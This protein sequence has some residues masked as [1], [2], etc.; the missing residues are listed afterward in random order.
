M[1]FEDIVQKVDNAKDLDQLFELWQQAHA[2]EKEWRNTTIV[3]EEWGKRD[4]LR[5]Y[6]TGDGIIDE[7]AYLNSP[8]KVLVVLKEANV[9]DNKEDKFFENAGDHRDWYNEFVNGKYEPDTG[10]VMIGND[11]ADNHSKQKELI[12]RMAYMVHKY[13]KNR[14]EDGFNPQVSEIQ[15]SLKSTAVMNL[16]KRGGDNAVYNKKVF[17]NYCDVY[18][19]FVRREIEIINPDII[20]WCVPEISDPRG[21]YRIDSNRIIIRM[22]HT[23]G[24]IYIRNN[25]KDIPFSLERLN[26]YCEELYKMDH[27]IYFPWK[28]PT[29]KYMLIFEDRLKKVSL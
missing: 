12:G 25:N 27:K 20:I 3:K 4:K 10:K 24:A 5:K 8:C 15:N 29:V 6:F 7:K 17:R 21:K 23:A 19:P 1:K 9:S 14:N 22:I 26:N 11:N 16:N 2:L 13:V 28:K 18:A